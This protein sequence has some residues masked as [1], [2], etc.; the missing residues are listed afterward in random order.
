MDGE[1]GRRARMSEAAKKKKKQRKRILGIVFFLGV[2]IGGS[3][4]LGILL[5]NNL[6]NE[7]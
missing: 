2:V 4:G 5:G 1:N 3:F 6:K 7:K